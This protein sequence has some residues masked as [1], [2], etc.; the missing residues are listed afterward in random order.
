VPIVTPLRIPGTTG[1]SPGIRGFCWSVILENAAEKTPFH[2]AGPQR[3]LSNRAALEMPLSYVHDPQARIA[4]I[5]NTLFLETVWAAEALLPE[6]RAK[7][8]I[9]VDGTPRC[10]GSPVKDGC[11]PSPT[12]IK[13]RMRDNQF[14]GRL[15]Q[16]SSASQAEIKYPPLAFSEIRFR[17][18]IQPSYSLLSMIKVS[19]RVISNQLRSAIRSR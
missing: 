12:Q 13:N 14:S 3:I 2:Q 1:F 17:G 5:T 6:L 9:E 11:T 16:N 19:R 18:S 7:G 8:L 4:Y 10:C 15:L